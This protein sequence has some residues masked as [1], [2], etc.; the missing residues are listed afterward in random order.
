MQCKPAEK[1]SMTKINI[2][3]D[4]SHP[5]VQ[6]AL[7]TAAQFPTVRSPCLTC[8]ATYRM[9]VL[10]ARDF[11]RHFISGTLGHGGQGKRPK[12][13]DGV[14]GEAKKSLALSPRLQCNGTISA[15]CSLSLLG[16]SNSPASAS[17]VAGTTGTHH[18]APLIFVFLVEMGFH[19]VGQAGLL[20]S[21]GS[22]S[23][24]QAT[25]HWYDHGSRQLLPPRLTIL[26]SQP[27]KQLG[28]QMG[29]RHPTQAGLELLGSSHPPALASQTT[30]I[31]NTEFCHVAQSG[32]ELLSSSNPPALASQSAGITDVSHSTWPESSFLTT[33]IIGTVQVHSC[34]LGHYGKLILLLW[35]RECGLM[36]KKQALLE[37]NR[38]ESESCCYHRLCA[39]RA[40]Q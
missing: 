24:A 7:T 23:V 4:N 28:P 32:L 1:Q 9:F 30:G 39:P 26:P 19:H 34:I 31:T 11:L 5:S 10:H 25:V 15:Q 29:F 18:H 16:S 21:I 20:A 37:K 8:C 22:H 36:D 3:Q 27:P 6:R 38:F 2:P 33:S 14:M 40:N 12:E 17:R 35:E 13:Q